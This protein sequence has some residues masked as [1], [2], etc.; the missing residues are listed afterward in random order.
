MFNHRHHRLLQCG[1]LAE[2]KPLT[3]TGAKG[4]FN[5][6]L[7]LSDV[8]V[9]REAASRKSSISKSSRLRREQGQCERESVS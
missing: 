2:G 4:I 6:W 8:W 5:G 1:S 7:L 3:G 9:A